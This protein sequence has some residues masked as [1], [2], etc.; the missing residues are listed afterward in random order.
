MMHYGYETMTREQFKAELIKIQST[1]PE[2]NIHEPRPENEWDYE[3][4]NI[5][6]T[7][8]DVQYKDISTP[9]DK[10]MEEVCKYRTATVF[11]LGHDE[12][13]VSPKVEQLLKDFTKDGQEQLTAKD[14]LECD[15][16][17]PEG[18][19]TVCKRKPWALSSEAYFLA[20]TLGCSSLL[21]KGPRVHMT[22]T[23]RKYIMDFKLPKH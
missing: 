7:C 9:I 19:V 8:E 11:L 20:A 16:A 2:I 12:S 17:F 4:G 13:K 23:A 22:Y 14:N 15:Y 1:V 21:R 10:I 6:T 3:E 5:V 18:V